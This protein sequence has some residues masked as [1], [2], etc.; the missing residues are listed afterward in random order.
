MNLLLALSASFNKWLKG[1]K[2]VARVW[3]VGLQD[4]WDATKLYKVK[5]S[6]IALEMSRSRVGG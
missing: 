1:G 5:I 6:S 2:G 4:F 3:D